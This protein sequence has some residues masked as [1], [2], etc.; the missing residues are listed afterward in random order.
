[1][2]TYRIFF[3]LRIIPLGGLNEI[4]K[5]L[6]LFECGKD[7]IAIDCGLLFPDDDMPGVDYV[8][9]DMQYIVKNQD[10]FKA[11]FITHGHED[12]IGG[13]PYLLRQVN[14]PIYGTRLTLGLIYNKLKEF[15]L[16]KSANLIEVAPGDVIECGQFKVEYI[17]VNHSIADAAAIALHTPCGTVLHMG[18]FKID[19]TPISDRMIDLARI[20]E[21]GK[22]GVLALLMDSTNVERPGFAMSERKVGESL[23]SIFMK[24][25]KKRII[26]ATFSSNVDRVQQILN[27]A[28]KY[29]RKVAVV[30]RSMVT[31]LEVADQLGYMN[32]PENTLVDISHVNQYPP[33]KM[34]IITTGSQGEPMSALYRMAYSDHK[35]VEITPNDLVVISANAIP[36]NEKLV[37]RVINELFRSG[38]EVVY[39]SFAEVHV[40]G[41]ACQEELKVIFGLAK[42][43]F[44]IPVHGEYRHLKKHALLAK[45]MG[46][47]DNRIVVTDIGNIIELTSK[48]IKIAG[49]V[50]SGKVLV[51]GLGVGDVGNIVLRDRRHLSQDGLIV[52]VAIVDDETKEILAEPEVLTRGFVYVKENQNLTEKIKDIAVRTI[53]KCASEGYGEWVYNAKG[54]VRDDISKYIYEQTKRKPMILSVI[55]NI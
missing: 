52:V 19:T 1:M 13:I 36:G 41:H 22:E 20:G 48:S 6:T 46:L 29:K 32:I 54:K 10:R 16:E 3:C 49:T 38:A 11:V 7:I 21:L 45:T 39:E 35:T 33:E 14:V 28:K 53:E 5:N 44:F 40:S 25:S 37:N 34:V 9:P 12:H 17:H 2:P 42:P 23:N 4:G 55:K 43:Q 26:V 47:S 31:T 24:A 30:G 18:D 27:I 8:I 51:D 50:P 15:R